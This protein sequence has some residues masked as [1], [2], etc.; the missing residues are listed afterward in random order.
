MANIQTEYYNLFKKRHNMIILENY[1]VRIYACKK[2][3]C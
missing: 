1:I 2:N 3:I